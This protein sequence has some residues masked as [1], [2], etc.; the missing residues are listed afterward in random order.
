MSI[1]FRNTAASLVVVLIVGGLLWT[2]VV[3]SYDPEL[4]TVNTFEANDT[5]S[6]VSNS[7]DDAL[8][9]I[10]ITSGED[11]LGWDQLG[12]S[13]EVDGNQYPCSLTGLSS[14]EQNGS[15]VATS[16][17][18]D[19]STF[20]IKVDATSESTFA[21]LDLSTMKERANGSYSLKFSKNDIFLGSNA[22]AM[23]V[24]NQSFSQIVSAPNGAYS[25]DDSERLDWYDYDFSVHRIDPKEQVYVIQE[26]NITYKLQ[27]ISYYNEDD[28]SRHIQLIVGWL[29]GPSLPA[30]EDPNLIAQSPCIIEGAGSSWSLN[31][32][33]VIHENG[34]DICKQACTVKIQIQ[35]QGV[36]VKAMSKVELL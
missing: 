26:G 8:V 22:T 36:N 32:I 34:I 2:W 3:V 1:N 20:A 30:F 25:L 7:S 28:E 33:V 35:Y 11:V 12:I 6:S 27:F 17:S 24:T 4:T 18:A 21:E 15:K 5:E 29:S 13:L 10:E 19:G 9:S 23:V 31:Q 14:V 16:L